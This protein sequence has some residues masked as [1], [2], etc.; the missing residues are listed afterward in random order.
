MIPVDYLR[1]NDRVSMSIVGLSRVFTGQMFNELLQA[2]ELL[3]LRL[4]CNR[5]QSYPCTA[6]DDQPCNMFPGNLHLARRAL[7][8]RQT[9]VRP[10]GRI[11]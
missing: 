1:S 6:A 7:A 5:L 4:D 9:H 10:D 3:P 8:P 2:N 11:S